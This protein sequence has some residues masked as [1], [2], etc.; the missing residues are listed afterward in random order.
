MPTIELA[1][2]SSP[3]RSTGY[4]PF[5]LN[6]G[7]Q[8]TV[9]TELLGGNEIVK[10]ESVGQFVDRLRKVWEVAR[11]RLK[12]AVEQQAKW[13]NQRHRPV[14]YR[15]GQWVLLSTTN[16][17][18]KG[19]PSKLQRKF[20]GPFKIIERIGTQS[21]RLELPESWRIHSVFHVSLLKVWNEGVCRQISDEATPELEEPDDQQK[22]EVERFLRWRERRVRN[23]TTKEYYVLWRGYPLEE[24]SWVPEDNFEDK[25]QLR[26]DLE[27]DQPTREQ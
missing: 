18:L 11:R 5:F 20:V 13:Y 8:P 22:Y 1:I 14:S 4:T 24:A 25:E 21:Y 2:N 27:V 23:H 26:R 9:P 17:H 12:Q 7:F 15:V 16:L 3:N 10:Q 19:T 6:Y